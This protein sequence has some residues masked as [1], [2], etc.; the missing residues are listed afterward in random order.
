MKRTAL[1]LAFL[2]IVTGIAYGSY[3]YGQGTQIIEDIKLPERFT[4]HSSNGINI[5]LDKMTGRTFRNI[6]CGSPSSFDMGFLA[7]QGKDINKI[8]QK[9]TSVPN[10]WQEMNFEDGSPHQEYDFPES[11]YKSGYEAGFNS[12]QKTK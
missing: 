1:I 9:P 6:T 10:C 5:L 3:K 12:I 11:S 8:K 2:L 4:I 7:G